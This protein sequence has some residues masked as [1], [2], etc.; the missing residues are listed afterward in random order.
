VGELRRGA[1]RRD[2]DTQQVTRLRALCKTSFSRS[3]SCLFATALLALAVPSLSGAADLSVALRGAPPNGALVFQVY[4]DPDAF[5]R[6]RDP[7]REVVLAAHGD[8][9]YVLHDVETQEVA[10]LVYIG[11]PRESIGLSN[12]YRPKGP[13][14][15]ERASFRLDG[16]TSIDIELFR[17][18]GERGQIGVGLGA[19]G[20]SSPYL[21][22]TESVYQLIPTI[23]YVGERLQWLGPEINLGLAG[24]DKTRLAL[25]GSYRIGGYEADD[26]PVLA[27]LGDRESTLLVGLGLEFDLPR[28]FEVE[29]AYR[30][31]AL[32]RIGGGI[33]ELALSRGF[34]AGIVRFSPELS[35]SWTSSDMSNHE[36]GV[37]EEASGP[38]RPAYAPG[39]PTTI[40]L[41]FES[42]A[43]LTEDWRAF[44]SVTGEYLDSKVR[45]SPIV[46]AETVLTGF[47]ALT[48][49]F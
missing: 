49:S 42:I 7:A 9:E 43:E 22:S 33:A 12:D 48:Y 29:A 24:S 6:F 13:P 27:D 35:L 36:F 40:G 26:S 16:N 30:H 4:D 2:L 32:D 5:G 25:V 3:T 21:G 39:A 19:I 10:V 47:V 17:V 34:Q 38:D 45:R 14:S 37:P 15:F 18:L 31:D 23:A 1:Q 46:E 20:R 44:L 28:G 41:G 11:I 8:G